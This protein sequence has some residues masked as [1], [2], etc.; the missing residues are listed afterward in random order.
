[1]FYRLSFFK[2]KKK[3]KTEKEKSLALSEMLK[4][5]P[6]AWSCWTLKS[7]FTVKPATGSQTYVKELQIQ[8]RLT[9]AVSDCSRKAAE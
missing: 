6:E 4:G 9:E 7:H 2:K 3:I 5:L 1:M 8:D